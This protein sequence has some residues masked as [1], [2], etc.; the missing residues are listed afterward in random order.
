M[1]Q[2]FTRPFTPNGMGSIVHPLPWHFA[3]DLLL[4]HF[5]SDP[6]A[7][8]QY[9]PAPLTPY[10][11]SGEAFIWSP[12]LTCHPVGMDPAEMDPAQTG[13]N[14]A[15]IGIPAM[16]EGRPTMF[17]AF[18]WCDRDWL[19]VL[20]WF[21]GATSKGGEFQE[22]FRH[23]LIGRI[24]SPLDDRLGTTIRRTVSRFGNRVVDMSYTPERETTMD[25]LSFYTSLLP[26]T[27]MRH[28]P[29]I[30]LPRTGKPAVHDLV[31]QI[32]RDTS[33]GTPSAGSA[34]LSFG[35]GPNEELL[36]IQPRQVLGGYSIPMT[37]V[38]EGIRVIHDYNAE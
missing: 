5:R 25:A 9:L 12:K 38:L 17:S 13:Y 20:S 22:T 24:G 35:G 26:L 3:G 34:T 30:T 29:D 31:Q 16:F 21:I 10:D 37:M 14:V 8:A 1:T 33:F 7:L 11:D 27:G 6:E 23:P 15:V 2:G 18:Q 36:P 32:M 28:M 19:I 4:I